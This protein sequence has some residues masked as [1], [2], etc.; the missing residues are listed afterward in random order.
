MPI[1]EVIGIL[2][3]LVML[4]IGILGWARSHK[5]DAADHG[6]NRGVVLTEIGHV[7]DGIDDIRRKLERQDK[8]YVGMLTR[9]TSVETMLLQVF[10]RLDRL[11]GNRKEG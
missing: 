3:T 2:G 4:V 8:E 7:K 1:Q 10:Q 9:L 11:E 6:M 5:G